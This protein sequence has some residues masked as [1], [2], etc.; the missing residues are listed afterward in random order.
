MDKQWNKDELT[1]IDSWKDKEVELAATTALVVGAGILGATGHI[2]SMTGYG[3]KAGKLAGKNFEKYLKRSAN[4]AIR[5][6]YTV[7]SGVFKNLKKGKL[8]TQQETFDEMVQSSTSRIKDVNEKKL[9]AAAADR[10]AKLN[11]EREFKINQAKALGKDVPDIKVPDPI[12]VKEQ[13]RIELAEEAAK[14]F[15]KDYSQEGIKSLRPKEVVDN[16]AGSGIAAV[17][18]GGGLTAY[19]MVNNK[20]AD[21]DPK[22]DRTF[23]AA[24]SYL[25]DQKEGKR[26]NKQAGVRDVH[27]SLVNLGGKVPA[28]AAT[29]LGFTG[30]S[31]GA[32]SL[33]N[34]KKKEEEGSGK[35]QNR[36]IIE[37]GE[38]DP[39][40]PS[41]SGHAMPMGLGMLPRPELSKNASVN[42]FLKNI[43][44]R[45]G[46]IRELDNRVKTH[47]YSTAAADE[48]RGRDV[49]GLAKSRFGHLL[50][51]EKSKEKLMDEHAN[52]LKTK[53]L[54]RIENI[55][56]EV[57]VDRMKGLG[58]LG[59]AGLAGGGVAAMNKEGKPQ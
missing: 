33:L 52:I 55:K 43:G 48:L 39:A 58:G 4:P 29:G 22:R 59:I 10:F 24:G 45:K 28:A 13:V 35:K 34:K 14:P 2:P 8:S 56:D 23:E 30:V 25:K 17:G 1:F 18:F 9:E 44:G 6:T 27:D 57:A 41:T 26:M 20:L 32:A 7:G 12:R 42:S 46:E 37:L 40:E 51:D 19:H 47:N 16:L 5:H 31:L 49:D 21:K 11:N 53:D 38:N 15:Q 36:I 3:V 54:S 50:N